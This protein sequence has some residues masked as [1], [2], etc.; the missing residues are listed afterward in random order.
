MSVADVGRRR[1]A[2]MSRR[3][4]RGEPGALVAAGGADAVQDLADIE[5][6]LDRLL[7]DIQDVPLE[8][9]PRGLQRHVVG[10]PARFSQFL[11]KLGSLVAMYR[12][13]RP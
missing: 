7:G 3:Q 8:D 10:V 2:D 12:A 5:E 11:R 9:L 13:H 4:R 1:P 6:S